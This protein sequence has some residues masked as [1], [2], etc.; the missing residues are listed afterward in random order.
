MGRREEEISAREVEMRDMLTALKELLAKQ[1][2]EELA[3][4]FRSRIDS[5]PGPS[6]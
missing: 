5:G 4:T 2:E 1:E 6:R 3:E